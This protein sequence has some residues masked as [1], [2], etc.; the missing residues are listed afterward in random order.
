MQN[1]G[2]HAGTRAAPGRAA[3]PPNFGTS[4]CTTL[5]CWPARGPAA[6]AANRVVKH[7]SPLVTS[8]CRAVLAGAAQQVSGS[9]RAAAKL[10]RE[11]LEPAGAASLLKQQYWHSHLQMH[12][13]STKAPCFAP[14]S[15]RL[16]LPPDASSTCRVRGRSHSSKVHSMH[17]TEGTTRHLAWALSCSGQ[18][19]SCSSSPDRKRAAQATWRPSSLRQT[20]DV[21]THIQQSWSRPDD[22]PER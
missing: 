4:N 16:F 8:C 10:R 1:Q 17:H 7:C 21:Q 2:W 20:L 18:N 19:S 5:Q 12:S 22:T 11:L 3:G 6:E 14:R 13:T 15:D 9:P